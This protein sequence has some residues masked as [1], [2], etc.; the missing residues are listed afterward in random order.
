MHWG[1]ACLTARRADVC[2][3]MMGSLTD[4]PDKIARLVA[5]Q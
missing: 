3:M 4:D 5:G 1:V 2:A